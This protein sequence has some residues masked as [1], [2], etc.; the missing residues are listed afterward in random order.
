M[1]HFTERHSPFSNHLG[2][3]TP[4]LP[5]LFKASTVWLTGSMQTKSA[6][7]AGL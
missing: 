5:T 4:G 3:M 6:S 1:Q 2:L 7:A